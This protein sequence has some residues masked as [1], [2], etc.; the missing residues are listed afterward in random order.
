M[1][2]QRETSKGFAKGTFAVEG[3]GPHQG[4]LM[5]VDFQN[6][7]LVGRMDGDVI[8]CVP[9]LICCLETEGKLPC[10]PSGPSALWDSKM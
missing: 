9:D 6:E 8:A 3:S 2:V 1:D 10:T 4:G 7:N 5:Q